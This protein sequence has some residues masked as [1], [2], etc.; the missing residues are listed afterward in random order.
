MKRALRISPREYTD[1]TA[2]SHLYALVCDNLDVIDEI[3]FFTNASH[4]GYRKIEDARANTAILKER[5]RAFKELGIPKVGINE[6]ATLGHTEN[7]SQWGR[8]PDLQ[9]MEN[10]DG[11]TSA[12][13]LCPADDRFIPY[14]IERYSLYAMTGADFIWVDDDVR[15]GNHGVVRDYCFCS[16]CVEKF[17]AYNG[18]SL[19]AAE[20]RARFAADPV[21]KKMWHESAVETVSKMI[22]EIKAAIR[23]VNPDM[24]IGMMHCYTSAN[25]TWLANSGTRKCRPGG[26]FFN[27]LQPCAILQKPFKMQLCIRNYPDCVT[28]IQY[29]YESYNFMT[30]QKSMY[31]SELETSLAIMSGCNG[32]LFNR[33][34]WTQE[35]FD[36]MRKATPKWNTLVEKQKG[37]K[38][39]GVYCMEPVMAGQLSEIG[40][41]MTAFHETAAAYF[42]VGDQWDSFTDEEVA[43]IL[44][45]NVFTDGDGLLR[46]H[47][48]GF[49]DLCGGSIL[50][51]YPNGVQEKLTDH[52]LNGEFGGTVRPVSLDIYKDTDAYTL[53]PSE[54]AESLSELISKGQSLGCS[55]YI[56]K[57]ADGSLFVADGCLMKN[58]VQ[59]ANKRRQLLNVFDLLSGGKLPVYIEK[60]LKVAPIAAESPSGAFNFA[61]VNAHFDPT[62]PFE[63]RVRTETKFTVLQNDGTLSPIPQR[64]ENGETVITVDNLGPW[65][66]I[67]L[68]GE[69]A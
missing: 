48:R 53:T 43:E 2:F 8:C 59:T 45:K 52:A 6:L 54:T 46:L 30:L 3:T 61:L 17:N 22:L 47:E 13:C 49:G 65:Q 55:A 67:F 60:T 21:F 37:C 4:H 5:I 57:R 42:L 15:I 62:G 16:H 44:K 33:N 24:E 32:A 58:Q 20:V 11:V 64:T 66:N 68:L 25:R 18:T 26:G 69:K 19:T 23:C 10:F 38:T 40:V 7:G 28:D 51:K 63:V 1:E 41:P 14:I 12:S 50:Q 34:P 36:M 9:Y 39:T 29:E 31:M 56:H 35:F 27:D